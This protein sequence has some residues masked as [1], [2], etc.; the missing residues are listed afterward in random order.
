M[1]FLGPEEGERQAAV[2]ELRDAM[3]ERHGAGLE[4]HSFYAF[5]TPAEAVVQVLQNG[6]LF[7]T[8]AFVRYRSVEHLKKKDDVA[9]LAAYLAAPNESALLVLESSETRVA[10]PLEDAVGQKHKRIFWEMFDDQKHGWLMGYFRRN[11]VQIAPEAVDL[12]LELVQNNT[13]DL[14]QEADR[15]ISYVGQEISLE[16]VDRYMYHAR[17]E[18]VFSLF[19][20]MM[21]GDLGHALDIADALVVDVEPVQVLIGLGWQVD[22]LHLLQMLRSSGIPE[23]SLF[24]ELQK[25]SGQTI[26]S[27]RLQRNLLQAAERYRPP[28]SAAIKVLTGETDAL[29]R[30]IPAAYHRSILHQYLYAVIVRRGAWSPTGSQRPVRPWQYPALNV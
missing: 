17:E 21:E 7:G 12:M 19:D 22:R 11:K 23:S 13:R 30:S 29:L 10:K 24:N 25:H 9:A 8:A 5:E 16:D 4:E 14:R 3:R 2:A 20:A 15:L 1:L 27:K 18:S 28:E 26:R 6:S